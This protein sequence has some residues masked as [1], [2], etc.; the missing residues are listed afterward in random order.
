[1]K[2]VHCL[3]I[4]WWNVSTIHTTGKTPTYKTLEDSPSRKFDA[5][6]PTTRIQQKE[7]K[8]SINRFPAIRNF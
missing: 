2:K 8:A 3:S 7:T 4:D 5:S 6:E 1:M